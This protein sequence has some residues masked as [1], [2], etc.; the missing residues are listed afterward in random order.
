M[1][2]WS[3]AEDKTS[4]Q[5]GTVACLVEEMGVT[6]ACAGCFDG[7]IVCLAEM[8]AD[9]CQ[10]GHTDEC[11]GCAIPMCGPGLNDCAGLPFIDGI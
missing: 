9:N 1:T 6:Q 8:C 5:Y 11:E 3:C 2:A 10:N 4:A 7:F